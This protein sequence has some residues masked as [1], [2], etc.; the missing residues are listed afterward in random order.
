MIRPAAEQDL[1]RILAI[2]D[3]ARQFMRKSG[4][5]VQWINGYPSEPLLRQDI[6]AENLYVTADESSIYGV[7]VFIMGEDPTYAHI[8]GAWRDTAAPYGTIHRIGSD[9]THRGVLHECVTWCLA[10]TVHLRIDTHA[11]NHVMQRCILREGF[12]RC[13]VIYVADGSARVAFE[14]I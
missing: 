5:M 13:G 4:N 3:T 12:S 8:D 6:A 2:Y 7:F 14:R 11:D 10:R 1:P 9:G